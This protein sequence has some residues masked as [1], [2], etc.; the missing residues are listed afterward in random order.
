MK[1]IAILSYAAGIIDGEGTVGYVATKPKDR[2]GVHGFIRV[3]VGNTD[4]RL[5]GWLHEHFGGHITR[6]KKVKEYHKKSYDWVVVSNDAMCFLKKVVP[7]LLIKKERAEYLLGNVAFV[8][9]HGHQTRKC[10]LELNDARIALRDA[11]KA[12]NRKCEPPAT[13]K[14]DGDTNGSG[15]DAIV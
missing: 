13:T 2:P 10:G 9:R 11:M 15:V 12:F 1:D 8:T 14:R 7:F 5:I 6:R 3:S 4:L